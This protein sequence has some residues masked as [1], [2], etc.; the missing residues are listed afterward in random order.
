MWLAQG[1]TAG[2]EPGILITKTPDTQSG[3]APK[4]PSPSWVAHSAELL[5]GTGVG[6]EPT[7]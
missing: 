3:L 4:L 1:H 6:Q 5:P 2:S 7:Q